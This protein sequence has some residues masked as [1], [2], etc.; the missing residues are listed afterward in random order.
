MVSF[1]EAGAA[2]IKG[3]VCEALGTIGDAFALASS[4]TFSPLNTLN[5]ANGLGALLCDL[6]PDNLSAPA[7]AF[8]GGQCVGVN[9]SVTIRSEV[10]P[11]ADCSTF[12][13]SISVLG[14]P[15]P[16]RGLVTRTEN[17]TG[18][19]CT[20]GGN[21]VYLRYGS[22]PI[23]EIIVAGAGYGATASI[24]SV[25]RED[26]QPDLCGDPPPVY[27]DP[28]PGYDFGGDIT[29]NIDESTEITVPVIGIFA[30][31]YVALDGSLRIPV[32]IDVGGVDFSGEVTI[33]PEFNVEIKPTGVRPGPGKP[34][35]DDDGQG[36]D[37]PVPVPEDEDDANPIIG[38]LVF[39]QLVNDPNATGLDSE[40]GPNLLVPRIGSVQFAI[41]T[42]NSIG[43][44]AD[45]DVKNLESYVPCPA[46]QG[47]IAVRVTP[48]SGV[49]R[50][51][52]PVRGKPLTPELP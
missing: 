34:D 5:V 38:V 18:P 11:F 43:W 27:P 28:P 15:G 31:I 40:G 44:T 36:G 4:V 29:Y 6:P 49:T 20:P 3:K 7:P 42:G 8:T 48:L 50:T 19:L 12:G 46:P 51:F 33:A 52:V 25:A 21:A 32:T 37:D 2:F 10:F 13:P 17:P 41:K 24:L 39:S 23:Q 9:Y 16:I 30:P 1:V 14:F 45:Q 35:G 22:N 47:A 26:G